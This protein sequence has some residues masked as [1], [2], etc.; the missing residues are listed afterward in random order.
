VTIPDLYKLPTS[1]RSRRQALLLGVVAGLAIAAGVGLSTA[2]SRLAAMSGYPLELGTPL[3]TPLPLLARVPLLLAGGLVVGFVLLRRQ[4]RYLGAVVLLALAVMMV[5]SYPV[6]SPFNY[7]LARRALAS[8][9]YAALLRQADAW[10]IAASVSLLAAAAPVLLPRIFSALSRTGDL[11]GS[12][13]LATV[14]DILRGGFVLDESPGRLDQSTELPVGT[15][16]YRRDHRLVRA[17]GDVHVLVFAPP[18]SG[19]TTGYVIPTAQDWKGSMLVLD[20]KGE[21][22]R[23]T[24]GL[25]QRHGSR[26][27]LLDPSRNHETLARYNPLLSIR[28]WPHDVQDASE[29]AQLLVPDSEG[30]DPFW[31]LS[32]RTLLEGVI[33]HVLY[34]GPE[35]TLA[36]CYAFLCSPGEDLEEQ[37]RRMRATA[38]EPSAVNGWTQHPRVEMAAQTFLDMPTITRG[39]VVANAQAALSPYADPIL[40]AATAT[41]DF[42]LEDLYK[43]GDRPVTLYLVIDP[44]S[45]K[46]LSDHIRIVISQIAAALTREMPAEAARHPFLLLLDEFPVF[47][48]M[49]VVETALAYLRGYGVQAYLVVQHVGQLH[50]AYGRSESISPNCSVHIAFAPADL[51]TARQLSQRAGNRTVHFE[52]G[53]VSRRSVS[54]Q[55]ADSGRPLLTP[56]RS[57]GCRRGRRWSC[58]PAPSRSGSGRSR[59]SSTLCA[60]PRRGFPSSRASLRKL[61]SRTGL[62]AASR[63]LP[64]RGS[65][66]SGPR[67]FVGSSIPRGSCRDGFGP[68]L[69][70]PDVSRRL[71]AGAPRR[72]VGLGD[73]YQFGLGGPNGR[74]R[75]AAGS[76]SRLRPRAADGVSLRH[77]EP[78]RAPAR[79]RS[80]DP[81]LSAP[82]LLRQWT[83]PRQGAAGRRI[84]VFNLRKPPREL[85]LIPRLI[86]LGCLTQAAA[87][88]LTGKIAKR[89][90]VLIAGPTNSGKTNFLNACSMSR[91][92]SARPRPVSTSLRTAGGEG[93]GEEVA[94]EG[95]GLRQVSFQPHLRHIPDPGLGGSLRDGSH[96][97][98]FPGENSRGSVT[99]LQLEGLSDP[100][101]NYLF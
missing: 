29:L 68:H 77:R 85:F 4:W 3:T 83:A 31:R 80:S 88:Y 79:H 6:Y 60:R 7:S 75:G 13:R 70:A 38:H 82:S 30:S 90:S 11:H 23:A 71:R 93:E 37:F 72:S 2:V 5:T 78:R 14:A 50:T 91:S 97:S 28:P 34:A 96:E 18:G 87:D 15:I 35:K 22:A 8:G 16:A 89:K 73:L 84:A 58:G 69:G 25:R 20:V 95:T 36:A 51:E 94:L 48:R 10:G 67:R 26:I 49:K 33:L 43:A 81:G 59:S 9:P 92:A 21:I 65:G 32:A 54:T 52:R 61:I 45:I 100:L 57:C 64:R 101:L 62:A 27:L 44:N 41:S 55:E 66:K 47:G 12:A 98:P 39:G 42:A 46:R 1:T 53:S 17:Q 63:P 56:T 19:K 76:P 86:E 99:K 74:H 40:A 24:A